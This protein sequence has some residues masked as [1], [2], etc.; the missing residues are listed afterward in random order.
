MIVPYRKYKDRDGNLVQ[1]PVL[2][3]RITCNRI[4]LP[5]WGLVDSGADITLLNRSFAQL[6]NIDLKRGKRIPLLGVMEGPEFAAYV[7]QVNIVIKDVGSADTI[8]AFTDSEEYPDLVI[9]GRR[10][11]FEHF[12]IKFEE[13]KKQLEIEARK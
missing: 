9:L 13:H 11:F 12:T 4:S 5:L 3:V 6:F 7:H 2:S 10:G 1:L 8:V